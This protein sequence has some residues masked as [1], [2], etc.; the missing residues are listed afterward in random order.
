MTPIEYYNEQIQKKGIYEDAEQLTVLKTFEK[1]YHALLAEH[2]K[3]QSFFSHF[4]KAATIRG[5]YLWGGVGVGKTFLMDCFFQSLP[6]KEKLR[7]HFHHFMQ[8]LHDELKKHQ[9]QM[10]PLQHIATEISKET[11]VLCFDEFFVSDIT[12]AMLLARLFKVLF[13]EG[14]TLVATSNTAPD[15]LYK[16]GLQRS[17]FLPA[18]E[19]IKKYTQ[20]IHIPSAMDYRLRHLKEAGVFYTPLNTETRQKIANTFEILTKG[21]EISEAPITIHGRQ[22]KIIKR[23]DDTIWFDF[24]E[25][26]SIPRSQHDY[27]AIAETYHTVFISNVPVIPENQI[28]VI[29]LFVNLVDV[30]YDARIKLIITAAESVPELYSRGNML[31][32]YARTHSRLLEMQSANYFN[33]EE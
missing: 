10:D 32:D 2:K 13:A 14:V 30:L 9:G 6:F 11:M 16:Y 1:L 12:D 3:R 7:L 5:I 17:Q 31:L 25:I 8:R 19:L 29:R 20:V 21:K 15:D 24:T 4:S 23:S 26:C 33:N 28:D 22:I 18:I 27:L